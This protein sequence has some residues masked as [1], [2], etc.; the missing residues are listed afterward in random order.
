MRRWATARQGKGREMER[1]GR[2]DDVA[3][4]SEGVDIT[5][6]WFR[7]EESSVGGAREN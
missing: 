4:G 6:G 7:A 5:R 3:L 1:R 2:N